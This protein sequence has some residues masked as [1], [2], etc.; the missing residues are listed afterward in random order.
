[1]C[2]ESSTNPPFL[3]HKSSFSYLNSLCVNSRFPQLIPDKLLLL[4]PILHILW[5]FPIDVM[6]EIFR[7]FASFYHI[8]SSLHPAPPG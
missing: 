5:I 6:D 2:R 1:M 7:F 8:L 3:L 4:Y